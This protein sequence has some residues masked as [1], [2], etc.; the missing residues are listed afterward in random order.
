MIRRKPNPVL[1]VLSIL[2]ILAAA[3]LT[4]QQWLLFLQLPF[5]FPAGASW[6]GYPVEGMT[7]D[8]AKERIEQVLFAPVE[9]RIGDASIQVDP[10]DLGMEVAWNQ[11]LLSAG[12]QPN[13]SGFWDYLWHAQP[14]P[15]TL[16]LE[17]T[18]DESVARQ[19]LADA[20]SARYD[21]PSLPPSPIPGTT[22]F[23][24]GV[25]G[26][27]LDLDESSARIAALSNQP[28]N[29]VIQLVVEAA[30]MQKPDPRNLEIFLKQKI[31]QAGFNGIAEIYIQDLE[32]DQ[33]VHFA[34]R[35]GNDL[36]VDI[37]F[38][39][40]STI[41]IPIL[42]SSLL[43][44]GETVP[45]NVA[46]LA[47]RMIVLSENPPADSLMETVIGSTLAPLRVTEDLQKMGFENTFLA[48]YFYLGAPLLQRFETQ[49]NQRTD[50]QLR[51]D[52]YNQTTASDMG[53]LLAALY[54]CAE[55][56]VGLL[57]DTFPG[58]INAVK[59]QFVLDVLKN[60]KIGVLSEAGL[61]EGITVA[62]KHGWTEESDGYLHTVSDVGI[63]FTPG[64]DY[65][66]VIFLYDPIQLLF[67]PGN[68]LIAQL[69]QVI[70]NYYNPQAQIDWLFGDI[71]YR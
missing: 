28:E 41:K 3:G 35:D 49:A 64:S 44:S 43:R 20:I 63:V 57:M 58:E 4:I 5:T 17:T 56:G 32:T 2:L 47:N 67:N 11:E 66:L 36:P 34:V 38:S 33:V 26:S 52:V 8:Q 42:I 16:A 40:A 31:I 46:N 24:I 68:E 14:Q 25:P 45:E 18:L 12:P 51:P 55:R 62:H 7:P 1:W 54:N 61:P 53:R 23:E 70:Y 39:A 65:V 6:G 27:Q 37:A 22:R 19:F 9:L 69:S 13:L 48:G 71:R 21:L 15:V 29:R 50:I 10:H 59:C 30:P 60:N